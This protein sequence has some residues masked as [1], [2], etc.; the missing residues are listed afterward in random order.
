MEVAVWIW[1]PDETEPV[2]A[3]KMR[4]GELE[5]PRTDGFRVLE[6]PWLFWYGKSYLGNSKTISLYEPDLPLCEGI[7]LPPEGHILPGCIRDGSPDAWGRRAICRQ[8]E[9]QPAK[10][11]GEDPG[12]SLFLLESASD[13]IGALDFQESVL[14]YVPRDLDAVSLDDMADVTRRVEEN[15]EITPEL[16]HALRHCTPVGGARPKAVA[17][18]EGRKIIV[19]FSPSL[20]RYETI[21]T[22]YVAMRLAAVCGLSV[23][24]V[25][26][27]RIHG[28]HALLVERFDR[29]KAA[30]GWYRKAMVSALTI[31]GLNETNAD[32]A[33]YEKLAEIIRHRFTEP[34]ETL[35]ELYGRLC[36]NIFCGNTDDHARNHAAFWDGQYLTITPAYDICPQPKFGNIPLQGMRIIGRRRQSLLSNCLS[37]ASD[38]LLSEEQALRIMEDQI[39]VIAENFKAVWEEAELGPPAENSMPT[40][41]FLN[42]SCLQG[43][44][45][46]HARIGQ[47]L[48]EARAE[49]FGRSC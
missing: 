38:F 11:Y 5:P 27:T 1:L 31:Q 32:A 39:T 2:V 7:F 36:F 43:L 23:A 35:R 12:E 28:R 49:I 25:D 24:P 42:P 22:E 3:G 26:M 41:Q 20:D 47:R 4:Q 34:K 44:D 17:Q 46:R 40:R 9:Q 13:R 6:D 18:H 21:P 45:E 8:L 10:T 48:E 19:K 37:V 33:S 30:E 16:H 29:L 15:K 14:E